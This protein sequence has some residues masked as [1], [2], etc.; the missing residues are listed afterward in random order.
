[1]SEIKRYRCIKQCVFNV[2]DGNGFLIGGKQMVV[3]PGSIWQESDRMIAGGINNIHLDREDGRAEWCE[4]LKEDLHEYFEQIPAD[5]EA[6]N[7]LLFLKEKLYNGIFQDRLGCIDYAISMIKE[8]ERYREIGTLDEFHEAKEKRTPMQPDIEGDGE[9][10]GF[11]V[12]DTWICPSCGEA[13]EIDYHDYD[14]CPKCGQKINRD[15]LI[16][17]EF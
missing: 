5:D 6:I 9:A 12:Y 11:P 1:M 15:I 10:D 13:Y 8:A 3:E 17:M 16:S 4:P 2:C 7:D 14:F